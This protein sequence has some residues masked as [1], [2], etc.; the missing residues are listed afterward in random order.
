MSLRDVIAG[1]WRL[2]RETARRAIG[3]PDYDAYVRHVREHH[4]DRV[5][6][7]YAEFF[8]ERQQ[9]RYRGTGGRCC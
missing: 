8:A 5:A 4:P 9:A 7:T 3:V 1:A 2:S 6:M